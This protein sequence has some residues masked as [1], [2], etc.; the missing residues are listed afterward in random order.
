MQD[1]LTSIEGSLQAG[2][3]YSA[4]M[5]VICL[6]DICGYISNPTESNVGRRYGSWFETYMSQDYPGLMSGQE[7]YG[8]RCVVLHNGELTLTQF[9]NRSSN[10]NVILDKFELFVDGIHL[11][12]A[13][14]NTINGVA[15]PNLVRL[16]AKKYCEDI[17]QGVRAW[18]IATGNSLG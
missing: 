17:I 9:T 1:L 18:E 12:R 8:L 15:Q 4:F 16:N 6:P 7:A 10:R 3:I 14:S 13:T 2:F 5:S 11:L